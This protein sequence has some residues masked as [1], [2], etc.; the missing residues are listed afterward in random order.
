[1]TV[2]VA[3]N[4]IKRNLFFMFS[5]FQKG[6]TDV[7]PFKTIDFPNLIKI[8]K[9]HPQKD[10][11][12]QIR[13]LRKNGDGNY[14]SLKS[15]LP[16]VTPNCIVKY[17]SLNTPESFRENYI[18]PSHYIY[19][20]I[21][22]VKD[23]D[24]YK[25]YFIKR[26]CDQ[27]SMVSKSSSGVGISILFKL[28]NSIDSSD[29]FLQVW[30]YIKTNILYDEEIDTRCKDIGRTMFISYDPEVYFNYETEIT[31]N[32][33]PV[34]IDYRTSQKSVN[35]PISSNDSNNR[36]NYTF[37]KKSKN[38]DTIISID[39]VLRK[40][41]VR[42][43]VPVS[44]PVIDFKPIE[45][46]EVFIPKLIPDGRKHAVYTSMIHQLM[47]INPDI[48][49]EI[50]Y[51]FIFYV[52]NVFAKPKMEKRELTRL[53]NMVYSDIKNTGITHHSSR[54]KFVHFNQD[55][56]LSGRDKN[57]IANNL[58]GSHRC[59]NNINKIINAKDELT[60]SGIK[61]TQKLVSEMTG[62]CLKTVQKHYRSV[63]LNMDDIIGKFNDFDLSD[64]ISID[65]NVV[66]S[67]EV[68]SARELKRSAE[69]CYM[70]PDCPNWV[71][72]YYRPRIAI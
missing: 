4:E 60:T 22:N 20:D 54:T 50:I 16:N 41:S 23:V 1:L 7:N 64:L 72:D 48:E 10:V 42:T 55:L 9:N 8:I 36:V 12:E 17:R 56:K 30:E 3:T 13:L 57:R 29:Y 14:K 58:N 67:F 39:T 5:L 18:S 49:V 68:A 63:P 24:A 71:I 40:L 21:D 38:V 45:Y 44:N 46:A 11:I 62:L 28:T 26:Y 34:S 43:Y 52:N 31:V 27:V 70:H 6:I 51:S 65:G 37:L 33:I 19:F 32:V 59:S 35:H 66:S 47:Y 2:I 61:P 15:T 69:L 25:D 53:C